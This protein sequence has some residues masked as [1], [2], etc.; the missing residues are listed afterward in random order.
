LAD[1]FDRGVLETNFRY[2]EPRCGHGSSLSPAVHAL[3]AAR[4]GDMHLAER[5]FR[6]A[7]MIDMDDA[8]GDTALGVH[9]GGLGGLWQAAVFGF[10]G[11][12]L[13][14]HGLRLDPHLPSGWRSLAF[15]TRWRG[16]SLRFET[17]RQPAQVSVWLEHG[18]PMTVTVWGDSRRLCH[19]APLVWEG[20]AE[21]A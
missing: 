17:R 6:Q 4:L 13:G 14:E 2:Y 1:E 16:R 19:E 3:L 10:G 18:R 9:M 12:S 20:Q 5:Y 7:A 21:V 15:R 11:L 8:R